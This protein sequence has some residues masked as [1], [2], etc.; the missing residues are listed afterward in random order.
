VSCDPACPSGVSATAD[1]LGRQLVLHSVS[2]QFDR[3]VARYEKIRQAPQRSRGRGVATT[4]E[5]MSSSYRM[6]QRAIQLALTGPRCHRSGFT[7]SATAPR[8]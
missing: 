7:T 3:L 2:Q 1:E 6:P 8:P 4:A 5:A